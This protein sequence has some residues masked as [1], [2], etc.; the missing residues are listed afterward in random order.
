MA[1]TWGT[2]TATSIAGNT[3]T[4][5]SSSVTA[6]IPMNNQLGAQIGVT[7]TYG[8][9]K[10]QNAIVNV[11]ENVNGN[12]ETRENSSFS[13][14]VQGESTET[15]YKSFALQTIDFVEPKIE[16]V[17]DTGSDVTAV[18]VHYRLSDLA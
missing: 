15:H 6:A 9:T 1:I 16:I 4:N 11:L 7:L 10:N 14:A 2:W 18:S 12:D 17:N 3:I 5:G 8:A 13:L